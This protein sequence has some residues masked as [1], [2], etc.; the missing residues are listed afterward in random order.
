MCRQ[1]RFD[2]KSQ[3]RVFLAKP[4]K[5]ADLK[6]VKHGESPTVLSDKYNIPRSTIREYVKHYNKNTLMYDNCGRPFAISENNATELISAISGQYI[7]KGEKHFS[8][9]FD[10]FA[11]KTSI[12]SNKPIQKQIKRVSDKTKSNFIKQHAL[13]KDNAELTT[14]ARIEACEDVRNAIT[15]A[16]MNAVVVPL[17]RIEL[18]MNMDATSF[19]VGRCYGRQEKAVYKNSRARSVKMRGTKSNTGLTFSIKYY[20]LYTAAGDTAP[21]VYVIADSNLPPDDCIIYTVPKLGITNFGTG[22]VIF[23][24]TRCG[25][26]KMY[27]F[28]NTTIITEFV[29]SLR[30]R[31][32]IATGPVAWLTLDGE[33][34]QID[35]YT[36]SYMQLHMSELCLEV[37]KSSAGTTEINQ[38]CDAG[39]VIKTA[40]T[41]LKDVKDDDVE[42]Q[43]DTVKYLKEE[44]FKKHIHKH[45]IDGQSDCQYMTYDHVDM[46]IKGVLRIQL[47]LQ[48]SMRPRL[49]RESFKQTGIYPFSL[50]RIL[51]NCTTPISSDL[52][53]IF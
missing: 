8:K 23:C 6:L 39:K 52:Y 1:F 9:R 21:P 50:E 43:E 26:E 12:E 32:E 16:A 49:M 20:M 42:D 46:G 40:K 10:Q 14:D 22:Y 31:Y 17:S 45:K 15:F 30:Q 37:G 36:S 19:Q 25:N 27:E 47:A 28:L 7:Q 44:V 51:G 4:Q 24:H 13:N 33:A 41:T 48:E 29:L 53:T 35:V 34:K 11:K 18:I 3:F 5:A 38:P 2:N